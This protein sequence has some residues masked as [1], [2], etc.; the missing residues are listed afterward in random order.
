MND[1]AKSSSARKLGPHYSPF[2]LWGA[3]V[4]IKL[5]PVSSSDSDSF[6]GLLGGLSCT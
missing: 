6:M 2:A 3:G 1:K 4:A 5:A